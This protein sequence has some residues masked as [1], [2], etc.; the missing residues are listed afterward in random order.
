MAAEQSL[1]AVSQLLESRQYDALGVAL[2][3]AELEARDR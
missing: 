1:A 2:D 3:Q